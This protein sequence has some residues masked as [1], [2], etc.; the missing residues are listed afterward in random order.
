MVNTRTENQ[1]KRM[2]FGSAILV[3][4]QYL[5]EIPSN[6]LSCSYICHTISLNV[7]FFNLSADCFPFTLLMCNLQSN[8]GICEV[9]SSDTGKDNASV[10]DSSVTEGRHDMGTL[11]NPGIKL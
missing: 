11:D 5:S 2:D 6:S 10:V 9:M 3:G 7:R 1:Y 4:V 8:T